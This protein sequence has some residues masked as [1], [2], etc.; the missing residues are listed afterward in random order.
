MR[1]TCGPQARSDC[2]SRSALGARRPAGAR[3]GCAACGPAT[4]VARRRATRRL[5]S[6]TR[7]A[8]QRLLILKPLKQQKLSL[9]VNKIFIKAP[10]VDHISFGGKLL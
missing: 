8:R 2:G 10:L 3:R 7:E 4:R 6:V 5:R 1:A 9:V